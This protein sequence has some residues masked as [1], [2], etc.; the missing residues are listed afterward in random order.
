LILAPPRTAQSGQERAASATVW[1]RLNSPWLP[2]LVAALSYLFFIHVRLV[3]NDYDASSFIALGDFFA[4]PEEVPSNVRVLS[5]SRG[6]DGQFYYRLAL[7]PFTSRRIAFGVELD[8]PAYRQQRIGYPFLTWLSSLGRSDLV[9]TMLIAVNC[10]ALC[11]IAWVGGV[12]ARLMNC[13]AI[14]GLLLPLYPGFLYT[15]SRDLTEII[16]SAF[17][18]LGIL[19]LK[20]NKPVLAGMALA[21][22]VLSRETALIF[23]AAGIVI[24]IFNRF[25]HGKVLNKNRIIVAIPVASFLVWEFILFANWER[26]AFLR[27]GTH[28]RPPVSLAARAARDP[29]SVL[30]NINPRF[31]VELVFIVG[32]SCLVLYALRSTRAEGQ[33]VIAWLL[34]AVVALLVGRS[35]RPD[36]GFLRLVSEVYVLGA[37]IVLGSGLGARLPALAGSTAAWVA[38]FATMPP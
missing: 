18:V 34:Y 23:V 11:V 2:L 17:L 15:L 6:F 35:L 24:L 28:I 14:W 3:A 26:L 16:E 12:Y 4:D 36:W 33:V 10:F 19:L 31:A 22:A 13:H 30:L 25:Y 38:V 8:S 20:V 29:A 9:P 37:M 32:L 1:H 5:G 7:D 27:S 21:G